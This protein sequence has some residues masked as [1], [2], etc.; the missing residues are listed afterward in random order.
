MYSAKRL[1]DGSVV[2]FSI[3]QVAVWTLIL[4]FAKPICIV[5]LIA[6]V[7]AFVLASQIAKKIVKP[8]NNIDLNKPEQYYGEDNYKEVEPLLRHIAAQRNQLKRDHE[9]IEK[10]AL[11]RQEF[12]VNVSHELNTPLHAIS[13]YAE[14]LENGMVKEEDIKPFAGKIRSES[15]P[16]DKIS[17]RYYITDKARQRRRRDGMGRLQSAPDC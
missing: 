8:I 1:T 6:L 17:R 2:R 12:T 7:L 16:Y 3:V 9:Q 11:I 4:G 15:S 10:T 14:L 5:I 13:G